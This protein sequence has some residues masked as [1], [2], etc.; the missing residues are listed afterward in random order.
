MATLAS[1]GFSGNFNYSLLTSSYNSD[2]S[3]YLYTYIDT[4]MFNI[5]LPLN[6]NVLSGTSYGNYINPTIGI[7]ISGTTEGR[8]RILEL[9]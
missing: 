9:K 5:V 2:S 7:L 4:K 3:L 6:Q 8:W 1:G